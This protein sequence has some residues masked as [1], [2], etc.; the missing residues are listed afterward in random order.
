MENYSPNAGYFIVSENSRDSIYDQNVPGTPR[1][2]TL[3][4]SIEP[5]MVP[6]SPVLSSS[7]G[8]QR[9][10]ETSPVMFGL[11]HTPRHGGFRFGANN[12]TPVLPGTPLFMA[13]VRA[14]NAIVPGTPNTPRRGIV[15]TPGGGGAAG[16][17]LIIPRP[18]YT[19]PYTPVRFACGRTRFL[20]SVS[21]Q[22]LDLKL[23]ELPSIPES[24]EPAVVPNIPGTPN[25]QTT[26]RNVWTPSTAG[27][28][29]PPSGQSTPVSQAGG[30]ATRAR[31]HNLKAMTTPRPQKSSSV[32]EWDLEDL[33]STSSFMQ[34]S[35][36]ENGEL[37]VVDGSTFMSIPDVTSSLER[38]PQGSYSCGKPAKRR[39]TLEASKA[40]VNL[41]CATPTFA[42]SS[43]PSRF[44][45]TA[46]SSNS[47]LSTSTTL[48]T[49]NQ[50]FS[51]VQ[52]S[53]SSLQNS[54]SKNDDK[55]GL[56]TSKENKTPASKGR[57]TLNASFSAPARSVARL[58]TCSPIVAAR[59]GRREDSVGVKGSGSYGRYS[60][61]PILTP[62]S[63]R[64]EL[65]EGGPKSGSKGGSAPKG[66][67]ARRSVTV[68]ARQQTKRHSDDVFSSDSEEDDL[69]VVE[70]SPLKPAA[71]SSRS[72]TDRTPNRRTL[73]VKT[74]GRKTGDVPS[75]FR[76]PTVS[77][78][79]PTS[80]HTPPPP[81]A[82]MLVNKRS[83]LSQSAGCSRSIT[84][85]VGPCGD[86]PSSS[87]SPSA[88]TQSRK[89]PSSGADR[90]ADG[91]SLPTKGGAGPENR[92]DEPCTSSHGASQASHQFRAKRYLSRRNH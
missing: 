12:L 43:S 65:F 52:Q 22:E 90:V 9:S 74:D 39:L 70:N 59:G 48:F 21:A 79:T 16:S 18:P 13:G 85:E 47:I 20:S 83:K 69:I 64:R 63:V 6:L 32:N 28:F 8:A 91:K 30:G 60:K 27:N 5:H 82:S 58:T 51:S 29:P 38:L 3:S 81:L 80:S 89:T 54:A 7:F 56:G 11:P 45:N 75:P 40:R 53:T 73:T 36:D 77:R 19:T 1:F 55:P 37:S 14:T 2:I 66:A 92:A 42:R 49:P 31:I 61:E 17:T 67:D 24:P 78:T 62:S 72:T 68:P 4:S 87:P 46:S 86:R 88:G 34:T 10:L 57:V 15:Y 25:S 26:P 35:Q 23:R 41:S 71:D 50:P 84:S 33:C 44:N 76:T